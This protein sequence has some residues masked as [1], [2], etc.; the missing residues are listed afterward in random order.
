MI[1]PFRRK[2]PEIEQRDFGGVTLDYINARRSGLLTDSGVPLSAT[3]GTAVG[4][5]SRAFA[6]LDA[7]PEPLPADVL[8]RIGADLCLRG[9]S[10]W[11]IRTDGAALDLVPVAFWD[12]LGRGRYHLHIARVDESETV[13]ALE[14]EVLKLTINADPTQPW[15]G[16]SPFALMGLSPALMAEIEQAVSGAMPMTGKGVLPVPS[17]IAPEQK[18]KV[19]SGLRSG[20]LATVM[21]KADFAHQTGGDRAE[22]KRVELTPDLSKADLNTFTDDLHNRLLTAAGVPPA[23]MTPNGNAGAMREA[24]RLFA[25]QTVQPLA[26]QMLPEL[27]RKLGVTALRSDD[28]MSADTAGRARSVGALVNAGVE[29]DRAMKLVGWADE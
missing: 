7:L 27:T 14:D 3:V 13:R 2:S 24:Y 1:W 25:L 6:M 8:A 29:L 4:V 22:F 28:M 16:R 5:W 11:H 23:L 10:C 21:S 20:S 18:D 17:T 26:R 19:L 15:R 9:E 12:D